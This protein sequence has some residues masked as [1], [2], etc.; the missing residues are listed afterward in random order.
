VYALVYVERPPTLLWHFQVPSPLDVATCPLVQP[1]GSWYPELTLNW[2]P[3]R[4]RPVPFVY[5]WSSAHC[6]AL[7]SHCGIFPAEQLCGSWKPLPSESVTA[8][9]SPPPVSPLPAVT[10]VMSPPPR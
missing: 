8:P 4:S 3:V 5:F 10:F 9:L 2:L 1:C 7:P 6:Q